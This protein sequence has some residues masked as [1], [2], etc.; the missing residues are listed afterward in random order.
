MLVTRILIK[1]TARMISSSVNPRR[2]LAKLLEENAVLKEAFPN[3][4]DL[5][6]E[7][8]C[9]LDTITVDR[10]VNSDTLLRFLPIPRHLACR[11][12]APRQKRSL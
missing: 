10:V 7:G 11:K 9:L 6:K 12:D 1:N 8:L 3:T 2:P 5:C 4:L